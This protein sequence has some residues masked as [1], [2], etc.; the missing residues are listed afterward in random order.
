MHSVIFIMLKNSVSYKWAYNFSFC[1]FEIMIEFILPTK[2][3]NEGLFIKY[4]S[5]KLL[6]FKPVKTLSSANNY[7]I[8]LLFM[9]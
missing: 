7:S 2:K 1:N 8:L 4:C 6:V 3:L 5:V 9:K